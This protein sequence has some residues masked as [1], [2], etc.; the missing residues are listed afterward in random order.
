MSASAA[1]SAISGARLG[2]V[3]KRGSGSVD[4]YAAPIDGVATRWRSATVLSSG[5][6]REGTSGSLEN[7]REPRKRELEGNSGCRFA[8]EE[9]SLGR[10]TGPRP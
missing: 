1:C 5:R 8:V 9:S 6:K 10:Q 7:W 2:T 4:G 3:R